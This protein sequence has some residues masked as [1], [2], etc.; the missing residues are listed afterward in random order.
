MAINFETCN[1]FKRLD[2]EQ[3]QA[4]VDEVTAYADIIVW[5]EVTSAHRETLKKLDPLVWATYFSDRKKVGGLAISWRI[6]RFTVQREGKTHRSSPGITADPN[7]GFV[8]IVL[9]E[10]QTG[11]AWP[12][13]GTHMTHQAFTS[14]PERKVRWL[15]QAY[16]LRMRTRRLAINHGRCIG[17]GDVNRHRWTPKGTIGSWPREGTLGRVNYDVTWC[18]GDVEAAGRSTAIHTPS[19][20]DAVVTRYRRR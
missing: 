12:V 13:I 18:R 4:L 15:Y 5:Q 10:R 1:M 17:G 8:D 20:H 14:H 7:R 9:R 11:V 16:R 6:A 2:A 19:D 3:S